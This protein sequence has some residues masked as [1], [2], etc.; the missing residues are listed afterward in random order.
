MKLL[1]RIIYVLLNGN[2]SINYFLP[3]KFF[4]RQLPIMILLLN[5]YCVLDVDPIILDNGALIFVF[6]LLFVHPLW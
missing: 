3:F 1:K 2:G 4:K 5:S 6:N